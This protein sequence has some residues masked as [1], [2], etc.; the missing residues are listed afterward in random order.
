MKTSLEKLTFHKKEAPNKKKQAR[1]NMPEQIEQGEKI[2]L[3]LSLK[4]QH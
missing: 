1:K 3:K 4:L 2:K